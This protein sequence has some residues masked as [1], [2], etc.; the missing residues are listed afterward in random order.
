MKT[1]ETSEFVKA[2]AGIF[3][4]TD[5]ETITPETEFKNLDEWNSMMALALIAMADEEYGIKLT[6]DDIRNSGTV[7][8]LIQKVQ[9]KLS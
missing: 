3:D 6:G 8:E 1:I 7:N 5:P 4:E 2:F 9:A